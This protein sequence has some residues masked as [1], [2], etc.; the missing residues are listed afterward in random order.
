[1]IGIEYTKQ[2]ELLSIQF[3]SIELNL[4]QFKSCLSPV[5]TGQ[6]KYN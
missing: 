4:I 6:G 3:K 5:L 2:G 1:M